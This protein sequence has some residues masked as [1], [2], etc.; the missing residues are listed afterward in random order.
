MPQNMSYDVFMLEQG[1]G[2]SLIA[3]KFFVPQPAVTVTHDASLFISK[4]IEKTSDDTCQM[5][6]MREKMECMIEKLQHKL[7]SEGKSCLPFYYYNVLP[8]FHSHFNRC[9][10]DQ[11]AKSIH[12][13]RNPMVLDFDDIFLN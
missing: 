7:I 3:Q 8:T 10:D 9:K 5:V 2:L 13:V 1:T 11:D 4:T 12:V 6:S